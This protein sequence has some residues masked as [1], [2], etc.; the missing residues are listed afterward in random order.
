M[1][2]K[3]LLLAMLAGCFT[4]CQ[5]ENQPG[6]NN[7][8]TSENGARIVIDGENVID[9][10]DCRSTDEIVYFEGG[11]ATGAGLYNRDDYPIV[12]AHPNDGYEVDYFYGGPEDEPKKYDYAKNS[13]TAFRVPLDGKDHYFHCGF[14]KAEKKTLTLL[15]EPA[16]GGS[17]SG[18]GEYYAGKPINITATPNEGYE[19]TGWKLE[20][21]DATIENTGSSTTTVTLNSS[22]S[23]ITAGFR[24]QTPVNLIRFTYQEPKDDCISRLPRLTQY[25]ELGIRRAG[26]DHVEPLD[27]IEWESLTSED[28]IVYKFTSIDGFDFD[29][30]LPYTFHLQMS[31]DKDMVGRFVVSENIYLS[32]RSDAEYLLEWQ[33][34]CTGEE[35]SIQDGNFYWTLFATE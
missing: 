32:E 34:V 11:Y 16:E 10:P 20:N 21:G 19:F 31:G 35:P 3:L 8:P 9:K 13:T 2:T 26:S 15:A 22:N 14:K 4:A 12:E 29:I 17:V 25:L 28:E 1:K 33:R 30:E 18:A 24:K 27:G 6:E 23:T 7:L 5:D